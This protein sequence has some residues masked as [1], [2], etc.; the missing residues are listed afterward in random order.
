MCLSWKNLSKKIINKIMKN[1][2]RV[3]GLIIIIFLSSCSNDF[4][5]PTPKGSGCKDIMQIDRY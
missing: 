1:I 2:Y 3:G 5:C 4:E